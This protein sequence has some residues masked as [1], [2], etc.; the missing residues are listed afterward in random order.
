[1]G[2]WRRSPSPGRRAGL[3]PR[4]RQGR[5][6]GQ[7][8]AILL[9]TD[10]LH[11]L[12]VRQELLVLTGERLRLGH[13]LHVPESPDAP[14]HLRAIVR[15]CRDLTV[16]EALRDAL[17]EVKGGDI[18]AEWF[19]LAATVLISPVHPLPADFM[20]DLISELRKE[21]N[22]F[23]RAAVA[24]YLSERHTAGRPL[25]DRTLPKVLGRLHDARVPSADPAAPRADLLDFLRLLAAEPGIGTPLASLLAS[26][27]G[28]DG[29]H[30]PAAVVAD[31]AAHDRR[32]VIIQ[33]R[34]EEENAPSDL[35]Y[36]R[37][38]YSLRGFHYESLGEAAP[39]FHCS[40]PSHEVFTGAELE[41]CGHEFLAN[42]RAQ[43]PVDW[44]VHKR[45][46]FLLPDSLLGYPAELWQNGLSDIPLSRSC[47]VV[48]RS[49]RRY[50]DSSLHLEWD[51]RWRALDRD[52][53]PGD[54]LK[55]I[56]WMSPAVTRGSE[57]GTA[58]CE[59]ADP[60]EAD[61]SCPES[62]YPP[63]RLTDASDVEYWLRDHADLACLGL[64]A[65]YDP[66]DPLLRD[67]VVD[68]LLEDGIPVMIW[69]RDA[70][71]PA[72]LLDALRACKSP[73]LLAELPHS[74][75][76]ARKRGRR[77]QL[78]VGK[79]ITLLWDDPTCVFTRQDSQMSGTLGAG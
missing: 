41:R 20:L 79:Q 76:E 11:E 7:L 57:P 18:G 16:L 78:S 21:A 22:G 34:V 17:L 48:V 72:H 51:R 23:G 71:D 43:E 30:G 2:F 55:R 29:A 52:C 27:L 37:R 15:A 42:W 39:E 13:P 63:L 47:Q 4:R 12:A 25:D 58:T 10:G 56:G 70:G 36:T 59:S 74:V 32:R 67:A 61:R 31:S 5:T 19:E 1:M 28:K 35:P 33:I 64:G 46:E 24:R 75:L 14:T 69:R 65:P 73:A 9:G 54:A 45:V 77:D 40:W 38:R 8:L 6:D 3:W 62:T 50:K 53:P 44:G 26:E 66:H 60:A 68:A 49:L